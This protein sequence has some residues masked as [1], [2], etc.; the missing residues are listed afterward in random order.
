M[1][2]LSAAD[3][4]SPIDPAQRNRG[5]APSASQ[6]PEVKPSPKAETVQEKRVE[7]TTLEKSS[8]PVGERRAAID[9]VSA[10]EKTLVEKDSR[11]PEA[12]ERP[13]SEFNQR[14]ASIATGADTKK[15]PL[16]A[17]Y[18]DSMTAASAA[19]TAP[20][21]ALSG[22]SRAKINRF[23]FR[24]NGATT[25]DTGSEHP[26]RALEGVPVTPAAGGSS[27]RK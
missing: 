26:T 17:K 25:G 20:F 9:I 1:P 13:V 10:Q 27:I 4:T 2:T 14:A 24:K 21:A 19:T 3:A 7:K 15:P 18:Q 5:F 12:S 16:V 8:A 6:R 23:V 22:T 11:R